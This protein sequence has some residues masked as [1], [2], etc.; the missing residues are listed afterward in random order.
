MESRGCRPAPGLHSPNPFATLGVCR[1]RS[2]AVERL[3]CNQ[4]VGG[5]IP[6]ASS[7]RCRGREARGTGGLPRLCVT[8]GEVAKRSN[9]SDCKSDGPRPSKVRILPS[10][11]SVVGSRSRR[12]GRR[13]PGGC[14]SAGRAPAF[15]AGCR[16]FESRRPL[17]PRG[18]A[19]KRNRTGARAAD[20]G[21]ARRS[22][23]AT[24]FEAGCSRRDGKDPEAGRPRS[25][26]GRARP[27]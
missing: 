13:G 16:G 14:S 25:S 18:T 15:Q 4:R 7:I 5:S 12:C 21:A 24:L 6:S 9:A 11:P 1:W 20:D 27:W 10:P 22:I 3:I 19:R 2:S 26:V 8:D 17:Q 23:Q